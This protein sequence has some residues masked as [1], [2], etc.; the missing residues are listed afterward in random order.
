MKSTHVSLLVDLM[1]HG[2]LEFKFH[3]INAIANQ[4]RY[5]N[6]H[7]HWFVGI[8][9]HFFSS[10]TIWTQPGSKAVVQE[11]ITRVL[12]ER[13]IVNKPHPWGLTIV[14]TELV[15]NGDY[16]FFELPFV[17]TAEPELRVVFAALARNVKGTP[18]E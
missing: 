18:V 6:S 14:F 17:R 8:I 4:L 2:L 5:P 3:L 9:L 12:L 13:H 1:N 11:I 7:T 16:G 15:K 10:T